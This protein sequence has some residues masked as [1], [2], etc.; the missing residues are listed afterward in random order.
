MAVVVCV[1]VRPLGARISS[2]VACLMG[3][4]VIMHHDWSAI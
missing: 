2:E 3:G 4:V 1:S